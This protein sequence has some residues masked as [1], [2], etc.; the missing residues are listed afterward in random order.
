MS[1][2]SHIYSDGRRLY[3]ELFR[4]RLQKHML[5]L[6]IVGKVRGEPQHGIYSGF[7][8]H[9]FDRLM[10]ATAGHVVQELNELFDSP[11]F[12]LIEAS[13]V[14]TWNPPAA[15]KIPCS[16]VKQAVKY[17]APNADFGLVSLDHAAMTIMNTEG[18]R[19]INE[20][21]WRG[22]E[23]IHDGHYLIGFPAKYLKP[24]KETF[25]ERGTTRTIS[26]R[27]SCTPIFPVSSTRGFSDSEDRKFWS[28]ADRFFAH[29]PGQEE[30]E[31]AVP[32]IAGMSGGLILSIGHLGT[33]EILY[34][35]IGIQSAWHRP[36]R[37][38]KAVPISVVASILA[39][40][41]N[42]RAA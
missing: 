3:E 13:W 7:I 6:Y 8:L 38:L 25:L 11:D 34:Q 21:A 27:L 42:V 15:N 16:A 33:G 10:W 40:G 41:H 5:A 37:I 39:D 14:D 26:V 18:F 36:T 22:H 32:D 12:E 2:I 24:L 35:V 20:G 29:V 31:A 1:P 17:I 19:P 30:V 23:C 4:D 28:E 9:H